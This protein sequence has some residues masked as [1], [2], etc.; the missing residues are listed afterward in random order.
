[1]RLQTLLRDI[2][3]LSWETWTIQSEPVGGPEQ[4]VKMLSGLQSDSSSDLRLHLHCTLDPRFDWAKVHLA[5]IFDQS[6]HAASCAP[7]ATWDA[8]RNQDIHE[9]NER[10]QFEVKYL[11]YF[12][13]KK[14]VFNW[15]RMEFL[16][17]T[18]WFLANIT[19]SICPVVSIFYW[20]FLFP[21]LELPFTFDIIF[22]HLFN[23][24]W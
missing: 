7:S 2:L 15:F 4:S 16:E 13:I 19:Q 10:A 14:L 9:A 8:S 21:K 23:T 6:E 22:L 18:S 3:F 24:L 5:Y 1:M 17:K 12:F 20:T 11:K